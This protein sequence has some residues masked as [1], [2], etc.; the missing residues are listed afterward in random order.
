MLTE[1][2][3]VR[4]TFLVPRRLRVRYILSN[5]RPWLAFRIYYTRCCR[6][7]AGIISVVLVFSLCLF[8]REMREINISHA[9]VFVRH[10]L[11]WDIVA[12]SAEIES[13]TDGKSAR[14]LKFSSRGDYF[15][16]KWC[17]QRP[18]FDV[19]F[20]S[21][22]RSSLGIFLSNSSWLKLE[23]NTGRQNTLTIYCIRSV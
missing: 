15:I 3:P 1:H 21:F 11:L 9:S 7:T 22:F 17:D 19:S 23:L 10:P 16:S 6:Y 13:C 2:S 8:A 12:A 14:S 18:V 20:K 5:V 4:V